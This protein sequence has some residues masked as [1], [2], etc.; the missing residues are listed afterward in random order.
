M[1]NSAN[2]EWISVVMLGTSMSLEMQNYANYSLGNRKKSGGV[3]LN[4]FPILFPPNHY[5]ELVWQQMFADFHLAGV[6]L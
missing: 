4:S 3:H 5:T 2:T 6:M 1:E